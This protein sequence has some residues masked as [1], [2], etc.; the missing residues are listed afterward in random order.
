MDL[1][2]IFR[3]RIPIKRIMLV[4]KL[5]R[6]DSDGVVGFAISGVVL[7]LRA[8]ACLFLGCKL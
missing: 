1:F 7:F 6:V 4:L 3:I 5:I 8:S 2:D